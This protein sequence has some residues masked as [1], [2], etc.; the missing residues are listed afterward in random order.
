MVAQFDT[1]VGLLFRLPEEAMHVRV[2]ANHMSPNHLR[3]ED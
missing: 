2:T 1:F 3:C